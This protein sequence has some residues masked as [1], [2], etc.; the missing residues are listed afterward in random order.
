MCSYQEWERFTRRIQQAVD[1]DEL[2]EFVADAAARIEA[3]AEE[4][5][6]RARAPAGAD[7]AR[8]CGRRSRN[9]WVA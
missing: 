3:F 5:K 8:G 6:S 4:L 7:W 1:E 2:R 9:E